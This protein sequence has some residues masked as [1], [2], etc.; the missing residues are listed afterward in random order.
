[1]RGEAEDTLRGTLIRYRM[2]TASTCYTVYQT[3]ERMFFLKKIL[4]GKR[5]PRATHIFAPNLTLSARELQNVRPGEVL[6]CGA[7]DESGRRYTEE[8]S[9][10]VRCL[11]ED[12][13]FL[14][15][16]AALT[17]EGALGVLIEHSLLSLEEM[18]VLVIGFGRTGAAVCRLLSLLGAR[19]HV[20]TTASPRPARA[21]AEEVFPPEEAELSRY[22]AVVN[23]VPKL[24]F[25]GEKSLAL[26][27]DAVYIDLAS[28]PA[29]ELSM[30]SALGLDAASYPALPAK[31]SPVSAARAMARF[32]TREAQND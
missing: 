13:D 20:A 12:E 8:N 15:D 4:D 25:P 10:T 18:L 9:V 6:V 28:R 26:A 2:E 30:L 24:L 19:V 31:C 17:A 29:V 5:A 14:A 21:F 1:M 27:E 3:D 11:S 7:L 32:V 22:D 23:T 16:N